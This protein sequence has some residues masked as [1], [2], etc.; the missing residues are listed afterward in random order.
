MSP[1]HLTVFLIIRFF[2]LNYTHIH[3]YRII[4]RVYCNEL[5]SWTHLVTGAKQIYG[6]QHESLHP[7]F[8][9]NISLT[10]HSFYPFIVL[11]VMI[12]NVGSKISKRFRPC[13]GV[14]QQITGK[15]NAL[16]YIYYHGDAIATFVDTPFFDDKSFDDKFCL[17]NISK[18]FYLLN[19]WLPDWLTLWL[20][21]WLT[22]RPTDRLVDWLIDWLI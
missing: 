12:P 6:I 11:Y 15:N 10:M 1:K 14:A 5:K 8:L 16:D 18:I 3:A 20:T 17:I 13:G 9:P 2:L 19:E 4:W 22:D 21:K 7:P